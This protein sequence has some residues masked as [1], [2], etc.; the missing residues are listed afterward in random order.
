MDRDDRLQPAL[1]VG[2]EMQRFVRVEIGQAPR[3]VHR[4]PNSPVRA[5]GKMGRST[6]LEPATLGTTN[7]CSNQLS[8]DRHEAPWKGRAALLK[9][10]R[11]ALASEAKDQ[12]CQRDD[13]TNSAIRTPWSANIEHWVV[14]LRPAQVTLGSLVL[15]AKSDATAFGALPPDALRRAGRRSSPRSRRRSARVRDYERI[16]YLMLMMVDPHVHFHVIPRYSGTRV[17]RRHRHSPTQAGPG[18]PTSN[19]PV[20]LDDRAFAQLRRSRLR[21][22]G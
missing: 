6:G 17:V 9:D 1:L 20:T 5:I 18:R 15:A 8:Y 12:R 11:P 10:A 22:S 2:D 13:A 21:K 16:N 14:L 4:S 3:R 19:R 7:R